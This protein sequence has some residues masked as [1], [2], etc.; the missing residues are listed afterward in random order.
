[1]VGTSTLRV[2]RQ[3]KPYWTTRVSPMPASPPSF[4]YALSIVDIELT[5]EGS[6][7]GQT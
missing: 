1:M 6:L 7:A 2:A 5:I 4:Q 3:G